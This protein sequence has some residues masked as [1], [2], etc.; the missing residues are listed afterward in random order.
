MATSARQIRRCTGRIDS[1]KI[2][3]PLVKGLGFMCFI[4][5]FLS[6]ETEFHTWRI[7]VMGTIGT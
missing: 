7:G 1:A 6:N 2:I 5:A 3:A 4:K